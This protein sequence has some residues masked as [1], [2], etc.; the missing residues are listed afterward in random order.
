MGKSTKKRQMEEAAEEEQFSQ[1]FASK[2]NSGKT[3]RGVIKSAD[4]IPKY[5]RQYS[6]QE[7]RD[8]DNWTYKGKSKRIEKQQIELI[9]YMFAAYRVPRFLENAFISE[10]RE[11]VSMYGPWYITAAQGGSL[12]KTC[13]RGLLTKKETHYFLQAPD[14]LSIHQA[15]WW[16]RAV[17]ESNDIGI[18]R[19]IALSSIGRRA[20][21]SDFWVD[22][23]RFFANNPVQIKELDELVDYIAS[24]RAE[25][26]KWTIK[27]R[28]LEAVRRQ[29]EKWH[30]D[31]IKLRHIGG[32]SWD[33]MDVP[34]WKGK[35]GKFNHDPKKNTQIEWTVFEILTGNEL[36]REGNKMRHCVSGYKPRCM[37]GDCAIFTMRTSTML[38]ND[39]RQ[40]T[41][42]VDPS[43]KTVTQA[44]GLANRIPKPQEKAVL[45]KWANARGLKVNLWY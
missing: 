31:M 23:Q 32:G 22:V 16:A 24:A 26:A 2:K 38:Y 28:S 27:K 37:K 40:V 14:E 45:Q 42:E 17:A 10:E 19:R 6:H 25:N 18:A 11:T 30:R 3:Y 36:A 8:Y 29:S 15:I 33:G 35:T 41:I 5:L 21:D 7:I 44:R 4:I 34:I 13:T 20:T 9:R 1:F 43:R 39:R 12:Y